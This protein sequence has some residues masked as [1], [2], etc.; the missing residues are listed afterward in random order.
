M[1]K[2]SV[3]YETKYSRMDQAKFLETA[4]KKFEVIWSVKTDPITSNFLK[5]VFHNV[6]WSILQYFSPYI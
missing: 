2:Y 3:I 6:T 1:K 4:F 5:V